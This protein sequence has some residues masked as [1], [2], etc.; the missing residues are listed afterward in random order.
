MRKRRNSED[1]SSLELLLDT[2]CNTFGGVMFIA[3][4]LFV[5]ISNLVQT[6]VNDPTP[7]PEELYRQIESL[8]VI[9]NDLQQQLELKSEE[10][11][12][13]KI[14]AVDSRWQEI[15]LLEKSIQ[16]K[17]ISLQTVTTQLAA[18][19]LRSSLLSKEIKSIQDKQLKLQLQA[20]E[21]N[22]Q[23]MRTQQ[24]LQELRTQPD[25][26]RQLMFKMIQP[27]S[28][29][30]FFMILFQDSVYPVGPWQYDD[31]PDTPDSAVETQL[32]GSNI[33]QCRIR[34]GAGCKVLQGEDLSGEFQELMKKIPKNR[35]PK[36]YIYPNSAPTAF[37]MREIFKKAHIR[38]GCTL[39]INNNEPFRYQYT[40]KANYEY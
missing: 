22:L 18:E 3:I 6:K 5:I 30:P 39:A 16:Q 29:D 37:R 8:R 17:E 19:K 12:K 21:L 25:V 4:M 20:N 11:K 33:V 13:L 14:N 1:D 23:I 31:R 15:L 36:F 27:G 35:I 7:S 24:Q 2:M 34:P 10:L 26:S 38:H 32:V 40:Q 9:L 28:E